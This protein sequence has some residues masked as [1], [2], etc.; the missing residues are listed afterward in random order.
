MDAKSLS[1]KLF[2]PYIYRENGKV[3]ETNGFRIGN[4]S[5]MVGQT[6]RLLDGSSGKYEERDALNDYGTN[7]RTLDLIGKN[8]FDN[9][10][11]FN[12]IVRVHSGKSGIYMPLSTG[13]ETASAGDYLYADNGAA[14]LGENVQGI[15]VLASRRT[16][17]KSLTSLFELSKKSGRHEWKIGFNQWNYKI[18]GFMTDG[19]MYY[20]EIAPDPRK[21]INRLNTATN[22]YGNIDAGN[23]YHNGN[24]NKT[25][26]FASNQ[27]EIS[28]AVTL[29]GGIRMEYQALRGDCI[30]NRTPRQGV[31]I[32]TPKTKIKKDF[33][34]K[35]FVL[36]G[37]FKL[38]KGFGLLAE[39]FY[40]EQAGHLES[41]SA[42]NYPDLKQSRI[43]SGTFGVYY[44]HP[45]GSLVSKLT[46]IQ[47]DEYRGTVNFTHPED[48]SLVNRASV[49]YDIHT[50]GWT[51]DI[52]TAQI[53]GF[54]LHFLLTL[55][56]PVYKNYF[57]IVDFGNNNTVAY[58]FSNKTVNEIS[59]ILI[60][61]DPGYTWK[62]LQVWLSARYFGKQYANLPNT[63]Y[64]AGRWETFAGVDYAFNKNLDIYLKAVNLL[65][66]RGA[67]GTISGTD[68]VD[69]T[70]A[71]KKINT[72]MSGAYIR[73]FT[74]E[75]GLKYRL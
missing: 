55:Q 25:A 16:P 36:S 31:Y 60:E 3:K 45:L 28:P 30:D 6:I 63:L 27:W 47:R 56:K 9:G 70:T 29:S 64:F 23:E 71:K 58:D 74:V 38:T 44:N 2:A 59:K 24:E 66:D 53:K 51:T 39:A 52:V 42:G 18:D 14:Y 54:D 20:Q 57:G 19:A 21:L 1:N 8:R 75:F 48:L 17:V 72:V 62:D 7:S 40:N 73:P 22:P 68:L 50:L 61:I 41:Y 5:Y 15:L 43:P 13:V 46:Y 32:N 34:N 4:D 33:L 11:N 35:T 49:H 26:V 65:N 69:E 10:L 37:V 67:Q 12:Y